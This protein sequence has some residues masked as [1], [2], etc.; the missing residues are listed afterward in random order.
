MVDLLTFLVSAVYCTIPDA[1]CQAERRTL[2]GNSIGFFAKMLLNIILEDNVSDMTERGASS[3]GAAA[4]HNYNA[5]AP[6]KKI[7]TTPLTSGRKCDIISKPCGRGRMNA[8]RTA[9]SKLF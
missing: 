9:G 1:G 8:S 2:L 5:T 4:V 3:G 6:P 7:F